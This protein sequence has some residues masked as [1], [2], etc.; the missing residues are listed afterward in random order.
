MLSPHDLDALL[1][2]RHHDPFALLGLHADEQGGL[3]VRALLPGAQQVQVLEAATGRRVADLP[4]RSRVHASNGTPRGSDIGREST[5]M[6]HGDSAGRDRARKPS[7]LW[8]V[9]R[10]R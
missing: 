8:A 2:A 7:R 1:Q 6:G 5:V 9:A 4:R 3:W 10:G